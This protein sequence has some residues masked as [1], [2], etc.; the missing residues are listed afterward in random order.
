MMTTPAAEHLYQA[1]HQYEVE[2]LKYAVF[3][4]HNK[5]VDTLPVIYGF[6]NGGSPRWFHATLIAEDGTA[7]GGHLCSHECYMRSDL[8]ILQGTRPDRHEK[9]F[10]KHYPDGYRMDFVSY[11]D[12]PN[13]AALNRAIELN[14]A[15]H[16]DQEVR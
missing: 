12:V 9:D 11:E 8:G 7:L 2:G 4:P 3:N 13:H 14:K 1:Q 15:A 16:E 6:N 5:P 10:Q